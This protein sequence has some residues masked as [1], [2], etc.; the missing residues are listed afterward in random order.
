MSVSDNGV[1]FP[2][3]AKHAKPGLGTGIVDAMA[4]QLDAKFT[5]AAANPGTK[6]SIVHG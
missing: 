1:G 5:V 6:V 4:K 2:T 3:D